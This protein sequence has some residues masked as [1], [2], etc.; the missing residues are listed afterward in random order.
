MEA[1]K[2]FDRNGIRYRPGDALPADLDTTTLA[3]YQ[4]H[5]MV[6]EART[7]APAVKKPVIRKPAPA[8]PV[9]NKTDQTEAPAHLPVVQDQAATAAQPPADDEGNAPGGEQPP[10][11]SPHETVQGPAPDAFGP[12]AQS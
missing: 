2:T 10:G 7:P 11:D 3:H 6:R 5:G 12:V 4:R 9:E 8:K 1:A